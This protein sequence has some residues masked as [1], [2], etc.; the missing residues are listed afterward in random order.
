MNKERDK[1]N[2]YLA[3]QS[4]EALLLAILEYDKLLIQKLNDAMIP[5]KNIDQKL[6]SAIDILSDPLGLASAHEVA[7][8]I[9]NKPDYELT[10]P[11]G[12]N[13]LSQYEKALNDLEKKISKSPLKASY[14]KNLHGL[15]SQQKKLNLFLYC[16]WE[17]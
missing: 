15:V 11:F 13:I 3:K 6:R 8:A 2:E 16:F 9:K 17:F 10:D 1:L 12:E 4:P 14:Q 5:G 7:E